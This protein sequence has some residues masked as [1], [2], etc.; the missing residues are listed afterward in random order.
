[1]SDD[2]DTHDDSHSHSDGDSDDEAFGLEP[3]EKAH[4]EAEEE[5]YFIPETSEGIQELRPGGPRAPPS[6]ARR[7]VPSCACPRAATSTRATSTLSGA[8]TRR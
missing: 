7:S 6:C 1:M 2:H 4:R 5:R 8:T 3:T